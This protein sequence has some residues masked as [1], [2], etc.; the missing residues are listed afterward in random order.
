ML[1]KERVTAGAVMIFAL[2]I[3]TISFSL[4]PLRRGNFDELLFILSFCTVVVL[5]VHILKVVKAKRMEEDFVNRYSQMELI[6]NNSP[7]I[8]LLTDA[9]GKILLANKHLAKFLNIRPDKII[10]KNFYKIYTGSQ[11]D[12]DEDRNIL[13]TGKCI[14]SERQVKMNNKQHWFKVTKTPIKDISGNVVQVLVILVN[15]DVEKELEGDK[16]S[17][18]ATITHDLKTPT[19]AQIQAADLLLSG[20][21][22]EL[23]T[24]Q[25]EIITQIKSSCN[26]MKD[27]IYTILDSYLYDN[28]Q[29]KINPASFD[30]VELVRETAGE[31]SNL[32]TVKGL[33]IRVY[34]DNNQI[35]VVADRFQ[36]KRVIVNL[37]G[38][39]ISYSFKNTIINI[40]IKTK[41]SAVN[42][43]VRNKSEYLP[44]D[45]IKE[46]F[47]KFKH[48]TNA[49][50]QRTGTGLGLYLSKQ[51]IEAHHGQIYAK[52]VNQNCDFGFDL[53]R[54]AGKMPEN[55]LNAS[56]IRG[57]CI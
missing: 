55:N 11:I 57:K 17:Y 19:F 42:L 32:V 14:T 56:S 16:S 44:A 29:T 15:T 26:Y 45:T 4:L 1:N 28:G 48:S 3:L 25:K 36:I 13:L 53:P 6:I 9:H 34:P 20:V 18:V 52:S 7:F 41:S 5:G 46:L 27:L 40:S 47:K 21:T 12:F 37:L 38:N 22:G 31:L 50:Y 23:S 24:E 39:A 49:K 30:I 10:G 54:D 2:C 43:N 35:Y 51:I 8:I 33:Q